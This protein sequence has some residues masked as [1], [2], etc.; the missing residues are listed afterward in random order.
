VTKTPEEDS[1]LSPL[2]LDLV[3]DAV[4]VYDRDGFFKKALERLR[5]RLKKLG[6]ERVKGGKRFIERLK[7][8]CRFEEAMKSTPLSCLASPLA[9][10]P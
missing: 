8:D 1:R 9:T 3:K 6:A 2:Y 7:R 5:H 10:L 4:I